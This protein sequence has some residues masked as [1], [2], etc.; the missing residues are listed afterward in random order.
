MDPARFYFCVGL[1]LAVPPAAACVALFRPN[2]PKCSFDDVAAERQRLGLRLLLMQTFVPPLQLLPLL[3][4]VTRIPTPL[5]TASVLVL[6]VAS[7]L[8]GFSSLYFLVRYSRGRAQM[9][10]PSLNLLVFTYSTALLLW[11]FATP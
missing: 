2:R 8:L 5:E 11:V 6:P 9:L 10:L 3:R 1:I 4:S 7:L